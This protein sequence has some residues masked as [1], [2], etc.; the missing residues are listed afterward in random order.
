MARIRKGINPN[1]NLKDD[2]E[3]KPSAQI[4]KLLQPAEELE[5]EVKFVATVMDS[6]KKSNYRYYA[7][8]KILF[9]T[10]ARIGEV[11]NINC[12][13]IDSFGSVLIKGSKKGKSKVFSDSELSQFLLKMRG[14][15]GKVFNGI[16]RFHI[17]RTLKEFGFKFKNKENGNAKVTHYFRHLYTKRMRLMGADKE[18]IRTELKHKSNK[19]QDSYGNYKKN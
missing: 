13:D 19:S 9:L 18:T 2:S 1:D 17:Y 7:I 10:G 15:E 8:C 14:C 4:T 6:L 5:S 3:L 16:T 12:N 11:L